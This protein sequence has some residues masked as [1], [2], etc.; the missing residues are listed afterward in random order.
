VQY[1][2]RDFINAAAEELGIIIRWE[3]SGKNESGYLVSSSLKMEPRIVVRVDPHYFRLT[4]VETLLGDSSKARKK[5]GWSPK[6]SFKQLVAE[7]VR[8]DLKSAERDELVKKHGFV[9]YG[10][11]E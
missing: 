3:G 4:E 8:E 10:H 5:L 7:M 1:S 11:N 9:A 6:I 2:V